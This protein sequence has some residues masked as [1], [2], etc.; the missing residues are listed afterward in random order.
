MKL[1]YAN[2]IWLAVIILGLVGAALNR[3][4]GPDWESMP[5]VRTNYDFLYGIIGI[6]LVV[7][8][9]GLV[10]KKKWGYS[11]TIFANAILSIIPLGI[12]SATLFMLMPDISFIEILN[13]NL[14]NLAVGLVS[15]VFWV[16]LTKSN[17]KSSYVRE[18]I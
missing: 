5:D 2:T 18:S 6:Y 16:L 9:V 12:F 1:I 4:S 17:A 7:C 3:R 13:I 8:I 10:S 15:L 11:A 14:G